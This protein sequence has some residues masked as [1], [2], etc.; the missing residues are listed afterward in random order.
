MTNRIFKVTLTDLGTYTARVAAADAVEAECIAKT[1]LFDAATQLPPDM[2]IA[3]REATAV[4]EIDEDAERQARRFMCSATY[5]MEFD[6][7][8]LAGSPGEAERSARRLFAACGG[9]FEFFTGQE[10]VSAFR[11]R[12]VPIDKKKD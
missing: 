7:D 1:L 5:A 12:E 2:S 10:S 6:I 9:P 4:G 8:V 3:S 11:V